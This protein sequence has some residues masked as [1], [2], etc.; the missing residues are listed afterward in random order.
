MYKISNLTIH[1]T[2]AEYQT[3]RSNDF[4]EESHISNFR[5]TTVDIIDNL[6]A[7]G[8]LNCPSV[9]IYH[10]SCLG[11]QVAESL[12]IPTSEAKPDFIDNSDVLDLADV[13][14]DLEAPLAQIRYVKRSSAIGEHTTLQQKWIDSK[15]AEEWR[16]VET[17]TIP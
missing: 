10:Y 6:A 5:N 11:T 12:K 15:G 1:L 2:E 17:I 9:C 8:I 7:K 16:N 13:N 4:T 3:L 14:S